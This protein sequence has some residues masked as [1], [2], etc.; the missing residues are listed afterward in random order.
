MELEGTARD[1]Q[2]VLAPRVQ[3][4]RAVV[5]LIRIGG[6]DTGLRWIEVTEAQGDRSVM[7]VFEDSR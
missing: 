6:D 4:M 3:A 5:Q 2:L 7:Q 1:W